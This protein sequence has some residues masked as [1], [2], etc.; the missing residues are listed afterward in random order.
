MA[1]EV[2]HLA[3]CN[4][5]GI[6]QVVDAHVDEHLLVVGFEVFVVVDP[7]DRLLRPEALGQR[8]RDD[9]GI[10][11]VVYGDEQVALADRSAAQHGEGRRVALDR[12]DVGQARDLGQGLR[13]A[14]HDGD[15]MAVAAQHA[16][17]MASHLA[18]S[19][20]DDFHG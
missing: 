20:N 15:L 8:G 9:V 18:G 19:R 12:D 16:G 2:D 13:I 17:Q 14:V 7:R 4:L 6:E 3:G 10:L 11:L 1:Q 5:L